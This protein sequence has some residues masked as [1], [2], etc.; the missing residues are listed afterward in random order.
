MLA[1]FEEESL[2]Y[3]FNL[4]W[5]SFIA[6]GGA[7]ISLFAMVFRNTLPRRYF[8]FGQDAFDFDV[9]QAQQSELEDL[10]GDIQSAKLEKEMKAVE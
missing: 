4:L 1:N 5:T 6:T 9:T 7:T 10:F 8:R 3:S 2:T